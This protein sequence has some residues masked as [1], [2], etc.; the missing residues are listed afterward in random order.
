MINIR[1]PKLSLCIVFF[2]LISIVKTTAQTGTPYARVIE[3]EVKPEF[4]EEFKAALMEDIK[5]AVEN[6][7]GIMAIYAMYDN[8]SPN[9]VTVFEVF[10][11]PLKEEICLDRY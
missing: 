11:K 4:L 5:S 3:I 8:E 1:I 7:K 9:H 10:D 2:A 6:E